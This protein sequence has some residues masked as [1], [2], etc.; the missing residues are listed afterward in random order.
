M[1][2]TG[3]ERVAQ[4]S[5][6]SYLKQQLVIDDFT[7]MPMTMSNG[8][9]DIEN[10]LNLSPQESEEKAGLGSKQRFPHLVDARAPTE[11]T[12]SSKPSSLLK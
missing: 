9:N 5:Q 4:K 7:L 11:T 8:S 2:G 10:I 12:A 1:Y 6:K 3:L